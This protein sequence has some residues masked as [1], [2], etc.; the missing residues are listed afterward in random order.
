VSI[1]STNTVFHDLKAMLSRRPDQVA[2]VI[3]RN[4]GISLLHGLDNLFE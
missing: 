1:E 2:N 4:S 3:F